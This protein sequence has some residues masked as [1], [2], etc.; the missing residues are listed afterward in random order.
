[1]YKI[2]TVV[3]EKSTR[4]TSNPLTCTVPNSENCFEIKCL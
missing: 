4:H 3:V 1:M 2:Y